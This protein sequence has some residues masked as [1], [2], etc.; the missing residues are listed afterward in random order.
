MESSGGLKDTMGNPLIDYPEI[1]F[2][3]FLA[4]IEGI[5][6]HMCLVL[7][8]SISIRSSR[9]EHAQL[10]GWEGWL[11]RASEKRFIVTACVMRVTNCSGAQ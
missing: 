7:G 2:L 4:C 9:N 3:I 8:R 6:C 11:V 1:V 5:L 10:F